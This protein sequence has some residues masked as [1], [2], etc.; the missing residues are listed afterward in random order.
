MT[1]P[2]A[3][4]PWRVPPRRRRT[5]LCAAGNGNGRAALPAHARGGG[6]ALGG[7]GGH[8]NRAR[9][10]AGPCVAARPQPG[11]PLLC[12]LGPG[13]AAAGSPSLPFPGIPPARGPPEERRGE[14]HRPGE[15]GG[16][17]WV[18]ASPRV[19][20]P[21]ERSPPGALSPRLGPWAPPGP[22]VRLVP[23]Q[24]WSPEE[25]PRLTAA[26]PCPASRPG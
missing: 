14:P 10:R 7:R 3:A 15:S 20:A 9:S 11:S 26:V 19:M 25:G 1:P 21:L 6:T 4:P 5:P 24:A 16:R 12:P 22:A 2:V 18:P 13:P 23:G 17:G 8:G